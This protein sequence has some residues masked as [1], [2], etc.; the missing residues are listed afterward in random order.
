MFQVFYL[1]FFILQVLHLKFLMFQ[2]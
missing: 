1:S 2:K